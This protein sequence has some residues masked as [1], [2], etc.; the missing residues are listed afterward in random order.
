MGPL[1][2][3]AAVPLWR[4]SNLVTVVVRKNDEVK[5]RRTF[6]VLR[7]DCGGPTPTSSR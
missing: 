2:F 1:P 5:T 3:R 4:G 6:H 7:T